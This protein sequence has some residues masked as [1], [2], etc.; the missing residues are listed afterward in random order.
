M[1]FEPNEEQRLII[2]NFRRFR[3]TEV[4]PQVEKNRDRLWPKADW[5]EM[6]GK[7]I[8]FGLGS[9]MIPQEVGGSGLD[10]VTLGLL[11]EELAYLSPELAGGV[12]LTD[13]ALR[14]LHTAANPEIKE[15]Y[16]SGLLA[17]KLIVGM[18]VTEPDT[19]SNVAGLRTRAVRDGDHYI[20]D[21]EKTWVSNA[22]MSDLILPLV[23]LENGE[24]ALFVVERE[25]GYTT[26]EIDK[27]GLKSWPTGQVFFDNVRVPAV[28][29]IGEPGAGLRMTLRGFELARVMV[30]VYAIGVARAA[31]DAAVAY[32]KTRVQWG[33]PIGGHQLI[34]GMIAEMATELDCAR[35]LALRALSLIQ[36]GIRCDTQSSMAKWYATEAA[37][38][39][40]S[41]AIQIHGAYGL[42]T[43][44][45]VERLFRDARMLT[46]PDGTAQIQKLI[47][48]R[49]LLG[50]AA[51]G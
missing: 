19:G 22:S 24:L 34:Q 51:F 23:R 2:D 43:E 44:Y 29:M 27:M 41:N 18:A 39:I 28:N 42:S 13:F 31:L 40:T 5:Q 50:I 17:G 49:N 3:D 11:Y 26:R 8:G 21:G 32:A 47:I 10:L 20:I 12:A 15:K 14:M 37:V 35:L 1:D 30:A 48:G 16:F 45:P 4:R 46:I 25:H 9:S 36:K 38:H 33:K 7:L 6:F